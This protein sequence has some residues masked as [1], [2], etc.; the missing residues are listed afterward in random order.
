[1]GN[2]GQQLTDSEVVSFDL[3]G[4]RCDVD[5][6]SCLFI[7]KTTREVAVNISRASARGTPLAMIALER[8]N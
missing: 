1:M 3:I 2:V 6:F 4:I 8:T 7:S 5:R